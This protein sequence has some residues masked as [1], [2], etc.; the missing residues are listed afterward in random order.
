MLL[1]SVILG[2]VWSRGKLGFPLCI[3]DIAL[4]HVHS[5]LHVVESRVAPLL[6]ILALALVYWVT[7][8]TLLIAESHSLATVSLLLVL[9]Y[10]VSGLSAIA[11]LY[12][13]K[14]EMLA[15]LVILLFLTLLGDGLVLVH[16]L[17]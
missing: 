7:A 6:L 2:E 13:R 4:A 15:A 5:G 3:P 11:Y 9:S 16:C 12:A 8:S 10:I 1:Q 17:S 14:L